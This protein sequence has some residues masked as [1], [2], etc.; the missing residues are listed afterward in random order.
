MGE[1]A[2]PHLYQNN[3]RA[4]KLAVCKCSVH[5]AHVRFR[6]D[7]LKDQKQFGSE[8]FKSFFTSNMSKS[9]KSSRKC[10]KKKNIDKFIYQRKIIIKLPNFTMKLQKKISELRNKFL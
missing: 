6:S 9:F 8:K 7:I 4:E 5:I 1:V 2:G 3:E 10:N